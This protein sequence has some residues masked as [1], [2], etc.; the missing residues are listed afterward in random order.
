MP[1]K[2]ITGP[3]GLP[4]L[5]DTQEDDEQSDNWANSDFLSALED[6]S[7]LTP[8]SGIPRSSEKLDHLVRY[9]PSAMNRA[10]DSEDKE[11]YID[12]LVP[13]FPSDMPN[14]APS[15][16]LPYLRR[17]WPRT[18]NNGLT[19]FLSDTINRAVPGAD[20][21]QIRGPAFLSRL[22][23]MQ[24]LTPLDLRPAMYKE[25]SPE[26]TRKAIR[27]LSGTMSG[28]ADPFAGLQFSRRP[29]PDDEQKLTAIEG[30]GG[31]IQ[32][33]TP[34]RGLLLRAMAAND[35]MNP[36]ASLAPQAQ[37]AGLDRWPRNSMDR[38]EGGY[39]SYDSAEQ[40]VPGQTGLLNRFSAPGTGKGS[41]DY[42]T[43]MAKNSDAPD[44]V[45]TGMTNN[46]QTSKPGT[47]SPYDTKNHPINAFD[48]HQ[49]LNGKENPLPYSSASIDDKNKVINVKVRMNY[50][51]PSFF[52]RMIGLTSKPSDEQFEKYARLA[53]DGIAK[54]WSRTVKL[55][56]DDWTVNVTPERSTEGMPLTLANP[57]STILGDLSRRS[58]N[59]H[60]VFTGTLY[61]DTDTRDPERSYGMTAAHEFGHP[62]LTHA[63]G[64]K[65]SWGHEGTSS[66]LGSK[67]DDAPEYPAQGEISL[68]PYHRDNRNTGVGHDDIF[69]R[70]IAS[71]NDVKT[72][73]HISGRHK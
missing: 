45:M 35:D 16:L 4:Y 14:L 69:K 38:H 6:S 66:M 8:I 68:M 43:M 3:D 57:G 44:S 39:S 10:T 67:H 47:T 49:I 23:D 56:G 61:Y 70:S 7:S 24:G 31:S 11:Q 28:N 72:L 20:D 29:N 60:P 22:P 34:T 65:Y 25:L 1:M 51:T 27:L 71:E 42:V 53:D 41:T 26:E 13:K 64:M 62:F 15:E 46:S 36:D 55:N 21:A 33:A 50:D 37:M 59:P 30:S 58:R 48:D 54:Y 12:H 9:F 32:A 2:R 18:D 52:T 5:I 19:Q 63:Y 17:D 40:D 73:I